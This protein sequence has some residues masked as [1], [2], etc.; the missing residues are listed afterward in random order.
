MASDALWRLLGMP[1]GRERERERERERTEMK[2]RERK[3]ERERERE[4]VIQS[5]CGLSVEKRLWMDSE[6]AVCLSL[7]FQ[8]RLS[9]SLSLSLS[10][11][12]MHTLIH[13]CFFLEVTAAVSVSFSQFVFGENFFYCEWDDHET[14][15]QFFF[16]VLCSIFSVTPHLLFLVKKK[17]DTLIVLHQKE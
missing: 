8:S 3:R 11:S 9:F 6:V 1:R 10:V 7:Q 16:F 13:G 15:R 2:K 14:V 17:W 5:L 12:T 4:S